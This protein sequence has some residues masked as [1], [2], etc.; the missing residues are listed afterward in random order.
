MKEPDPKIRTMISKDLESVLSIEKASFP[1][2]WTRNMFQ[3]ELD[4]SF[5]RHFIISKVDA[6][7]NSQLIGYIIFWIVHDETQLQRIAVKS[8]L[9]G[10][11]IGSLLIREMIRICALEGVAKGTLEVRSS[12]ETALLLYRKFGFFVDGVRKGYYTDTRE[13]ALIMSFKIERI[14]DDTNENES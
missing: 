10:Q 13:D 9:R 4:L 7:G 3:Q 6:Q 2:P 12:N 11:G 5:S 14:T 1:A 8:N